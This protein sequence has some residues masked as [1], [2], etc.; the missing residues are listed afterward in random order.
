M[1]VTSIHIVEDLLKP[2]AMKKTI[3]LFLILL[4]IATFGQTKIVGRAIDKELKSPIKNLQISIGK[5][6]IETYTNQLGFFEIALN[7]SIKTITVEHVS[8]GVYE[9]LLPA[10]DKF[11]FALEK[12]VL[13]IPLIDIRSFSKDTTESFN[14][15]TEIIKKETSKSIDFE[16]GIT[17]LRNFLGENIIIDE[18]IEDNFICLFPD[19]TFWVD[20]YFTVN[21][22]GLATDVQ[23]IGDTLLGMGNLIANTI[24]KAKWR[25]AIQRGEECEQKVKLKI[26]FGN[27]AY[28]VTDDPASFPGSKSVGDLTT[29]NK[30]VKENLRYPREAQKRGI[31]GVV[32]VSFVINKKGQIVKDKVKVVKGLGYGF[33]EAAIRLIS[34]CPDWNPASHRGRNVY[35]NLLLPIRF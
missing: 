31:K 13:D 35:Q 8:Y 20:V 27:Y 4:S 23:I 24:S 9:V 7:D 12:Q 32:Y 26:Y 34:N 14:K 28:Q 11:V 2:L 16:G 22:V 15:D 18:S 21:K 19:T 25:P 10:Q 33:D 30:Y 29:F 6:S 3:T 1:S 5:D 17:G